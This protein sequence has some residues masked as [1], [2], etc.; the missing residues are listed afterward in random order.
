MNGWDADYSVR[1]RLWGGAAGELPVL[2]KGSRVLECGCGNGKTLAAMNSHGW[3]AVGVDISPAAVSLAEDTGCTAVVADITALPFADCSFDAV[4]AWHVLGH[5][6]RAL[7]QPAAQEMCRVLRPSG[8]IF[9]KGFSR[10]DMRCGKGT[11]VE[12][13]SYLRGDGIVTHY[14]SE[15][16]LHE[17]FGEGE[18]TRVSWSMRVR[19]TE[20]EREELCGVF[21]RSPHE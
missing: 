13:F 5:L 7:W 17:V 2:P 8:N 21:R 4:F 10:N 6:P 16:D 15:Q 1:G 11:E 9:F 18:L 20:Y 3:D 19:G 12:P 14:F